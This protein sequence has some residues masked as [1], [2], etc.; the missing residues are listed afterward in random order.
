MNKH[1][2]LWKSW[3]TRWS[4]E[5]SLD[6]PKWLPGPNTRIGVGTA[7]DLVGFG[8]GGIAAV[9]ANTRDRYVHLTDR[10]GLRVY[11]DYADAYAHLKQLREDGHRTLLVVVQ[12][13]KALRPL[14][15]DPEGRFEYHDFGPGTTRIDPL[16]IDLTGESR[17]F[18]SLIRTRDGA[19]AWEFANHGRAQVLLS[20][21]PMIIAHSCELPSYPYN[22][23]VVI[24]DSLTD[25]PLI[26]E[27]EFPEGIL[28]RSIENS[29]QLNSSGD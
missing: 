10:D 15:M 21:D 16:R 27:D 24:P 18:A 8:C 12:S 7:R 5:P 25:S 26:P 2:F 17:N 19:Y 1:V 3:R 11:L 13:E 29:D 22:Y 23:Y 14:G 6:W 28:P 20:G 9:R 4:G